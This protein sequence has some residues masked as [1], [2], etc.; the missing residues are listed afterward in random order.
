MTGTVH[1]TGYPA[2]T[3]GGT[4]RYTHVLIAEKS[5][6]R[7]L[8]K[9]LCVHHINGNKLDNHPNNL[10]ICP[11]DSYHQLLHMRTRALEACGNPAWRICARCKQYDDLKNLVRHTE[12]QLI[13]RKCRLEFQRS[14]RKAK[15]GYRP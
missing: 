12:R 2:T 4:W 5:L 7:K 3:I 11:D 10:V 1:H 8:T 13:H 14:Y 9:P 6:G 15:V